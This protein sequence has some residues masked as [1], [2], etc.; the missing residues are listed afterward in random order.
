MNDKVKIAV[1]IAVALVSA[2][3]LYM[4][5]SPYQSCVRGLKEGGAPD[6]VASG[7]CAR[8]LGGGG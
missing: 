4:Y 8:M 1:I 5:F 6:Y 3:V 7:Q 2:V